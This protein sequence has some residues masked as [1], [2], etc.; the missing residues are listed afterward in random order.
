MGLRRDSDET[1]GPSAA[2]AL[3]TTP[4]GS[5]S[6]PGPIN[7][8]PTIGDVARTIGPADE[9]ESSWTPGADPEPTRARSAA[10][11][12]GKFKGKIRS[13]HSVWAHR[14]RTYHHLRAESL[15]ALQLALSSGGAAGDGPGL[16]S[17]PC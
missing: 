7:T 15:S 3:G 6:E 11:K 8:N 5:S 12:S 4:P 16:L 13:A 14:R 9:S 2:A 1:R 17:L 10:K